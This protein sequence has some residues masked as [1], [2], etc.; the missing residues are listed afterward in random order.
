VL[1]DFVPVVLVLVA[2]APTGDVVFPAS[3]A[4]VVVAVAVVP[5]SKF[6][7]PSKVSV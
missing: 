2:V 5:V 4:V 7:D 6:P 3:A 1:V